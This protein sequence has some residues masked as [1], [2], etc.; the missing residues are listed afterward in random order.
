MQKNNQS[1]RTLP[2]IADIWT[3]YINDTM[4]KHVLTYFLKKCKDRKVKAILKQSIKMSEKH[5]DTL[6]SMFKQEKY[7]IPKGFTEADVHYEAPKLFSDHLVLA[8]LQV[9]TLHGMSSYSL[10]VTTSIRSDQRR[11]F[12]QCLIETSDLYDTIVRTMLDKGIYSE[13][14]RS[15]PPSGIDFIENQNYLTGWFGRKRSLNAIEISGLHY[16]YIKTMMKVVLEIAFSQVA[17]SNEVRDYLLRGIKV[18]EG[19]MEEINTLL[20]KDHISSP[21]DWQSEI[22]NSTVPPFSDKLMLFHVVS[23][24]A[25]AIG[26]YGAAISAATRRDIALKYSKF[27]AEIGLYAEDGTN[28]LIRNGWMEQPPMVENRKALAK[29]K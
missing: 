21:K 3:Q 1:R 23:L 11:Y 22:T 16:N 13:P 15:T 12:Q 25:A 24:I 27:I 28:L 5:I 8:Y 7:P 20:N 17:Q 29:K 10:C 4:S 26:Y 19:Q 18:C 6:K 9:M 14:P 2:E